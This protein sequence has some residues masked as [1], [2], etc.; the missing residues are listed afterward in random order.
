[1]PFKKGQPR[2]KTAG[3]K[4]GS[5]NKT[6]ASVKAA[7]IAALLAIGA[8]VY[9]SFGPVGLAA[10]AMVSFILL[11]GV[12]HKNL[13]AIKTTSQKLGPVFTALSAPLWLMNPTVPGRA[14]A[15]AERAPFGA[16]PRWKFLRHSTGSR[17]SRH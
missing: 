11:L 17:G 4:K 9:I 2:P 16:P 10:A 6:T 13:D 14:I 12:I 3:R 15:L 5:V 7:L 1:M 8:A